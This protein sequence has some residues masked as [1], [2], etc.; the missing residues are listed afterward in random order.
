M[1]KFQKNEGLSQ[2]PHS[3]NTN[4]HMKHILITSFEA[5]HHLEQPHR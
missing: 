1:I 5:L 4:I 3:K 2:A